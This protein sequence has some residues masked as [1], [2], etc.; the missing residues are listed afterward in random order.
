MMFCP[1]CGSLLK[2]KSDKK[3]KI[4]ACSCGYTTSQDIDTAN[5]KEKVRQEEKKIGIISDDD[6]INPEIEAKCPKCGH[7]TATY[8]TQQMRSSDEPE[9]K[10]LRCK[11]CKH[12]WRDQS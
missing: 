11:K 1:K 4:L 8:W 7:M 2:P 5:I 3:K 9:T 12:I 6:K 10:F